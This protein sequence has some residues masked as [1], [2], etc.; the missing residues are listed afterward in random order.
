M[1]HLFLVVV[2]TVSIAS[3]AMAQSGSGYGIKG[4]LNYISQN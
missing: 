2:F 4:G 3:S 1:K